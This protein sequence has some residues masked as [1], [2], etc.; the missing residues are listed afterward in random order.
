MLENHADEVF[1]P[2]I[3]KQLL[4]EDR[5]DQF[6]DALYGDV[7]EGAYGISL[8]FKAQRQDKLQFEFHLKRRP[9]KCL[10][11]NLTYGLPQVFSRNPIIDVEGIVQKINNLLDGSAQ[12][13]KWEL[14]RTQEIS[15][16]LHVIPLTVF[17]NEKPS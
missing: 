6:F 16:E 1:T 15:D 7:S 4:P 8:E 5:T 2:E 3:L 14:G 17:L 12:C 11:C 10:V 13:A 9:G